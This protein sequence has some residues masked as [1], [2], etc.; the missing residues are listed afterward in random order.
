MAELFDAQTKDNIE[1]RMAQTLKTVTGS[2]KST[3]EGTFSRDLIDTNAV[4]FENSYAEM[5]LLRDAAFA[6]TSW[7]EYLTLRA[8]EFGIDRKQAVKAKGHVTVTGSSGS[9]VIKKSLFQTPEGVCF[10]TTEEAMIPLAKNS[11]TIPIEAAEAGT[12]GNVE[13]GLITEIPYSIPGIYTVTNAEACTDG[14]D[15]ETDEALLERLLFK[16]RQPIT[17]GNANHYRY[18]AMSVDGVGNCKVLP[19]WN[20]NGT[21]KVIIVTNENT[22]ASKE[23]IEDVAAYI[24]EK[25]PIGATVTVVSPKLLSIDITAVIYGK[26]NTEAVKKAITAYLKKDGFRLSYVS[27]A[28]IGKM[29][30]EVDGITDYDAL[31]LNGQER[32][33]P[34]T[35]EQLPVIGKVVLRHAEE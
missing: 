26:A 10:Y 27:I 28:H 4:E 2:D 30:L 13:A 16:V 17:S 3:V 15:E 20:G 8:S 31:Q 22:P 6:E 9:Y 1:E 35:S 21:V 33:I 24:E 14:A 18:W 29:L 23:L 5:A 32:N 34:L 12:S 11:V 25:R 19:L 7:G